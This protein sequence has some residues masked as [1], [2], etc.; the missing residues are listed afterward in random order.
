MMVARIAETVASLMSPVVHSSGH[1]QSHQQQQQQQ[2]ENISLQVS[3]CTQSTTRLQ[4]QQPP[5]WMSWNLGMTTSTSNNNVESREFYHGMQLSSS[6]SSSSTGVAAGR[7]QATADRHIIPDKSLDWKKQLGLI[8]RLEHPAARD[9]L[10]HPIAGFPLDDDNGCSLTSLVNGYKTAT[11]FGGDLQPR[12]TTTGSFIVPGCA[13]FTHGS[14]LGLLSNSSIPPASRH[15]APKSSLFEFGGTRGSCS[16]P[17]F[18]VA[19]SPVTVDPAMPPKQLMA[20]PDAAAGLV[21][22]H[23]S[24]NH[25]HAATSCCLDSPPSMVDSDHSNSSAASLISFD[26]SSLQEDAGQYNVVQNPSNNSFTWMQQQAAENSFVDSRFWMQHQPSTTMSPDLHASVHRPIAATSTAISESDFSEDT[27]SA[28]RMNPASTLDNVTAG[29]GKLGHLAGS[30][31][32]PHAVVVGSADESTHNRGPRS[33]CPQ[34]QWV[35]QQTMQSSTGQ[36]G[37]DC[38]RLEPTLCQVDL[39]AHGL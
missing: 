23:G 27:I 37:M 4:Q 16:T 19:G 5:P 30:V 6:S 10:V 13:E 22:F 12:V 21:S 2:A 24:T 17:S 25:D 29:I 11:S 14:A 36:Q 3:S 7:M 26:E 38:R 20:S 39:S 35:D 28:F 15:H 33:W 32:R 34:Q 8:S 18:C 9:Q 31:R 1:D